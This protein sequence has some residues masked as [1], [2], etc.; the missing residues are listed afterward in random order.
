[1][2]PAG[3]PIPPHDL[4]E[5]RWRAVVDVQNVAVERAYERDAVVGKVAVSCRA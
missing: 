2:H 5:T 1:L 3:V 4:E